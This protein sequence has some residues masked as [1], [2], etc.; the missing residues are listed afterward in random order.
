MA[1]KTRIDR[2]GTIRSITSIART[3]VQARTHWSYTKREAVNR[4]RRIIDD[5]FFAELVNVSDSISKN[6]QTFF[7][8]AVGSSD[9]ANINGEKVVI[10]SQAITDDGGIGKNFESPANADSF[11]VSDVLGFELAS[12]NAVFNVAKIGAFYFNGEGDDFEFFT[13]SVTISD[14]V[15]LN[16]TKVLSETATISDSIGL[17]IQLT[18]SDSVTISDSI[19]QS[20]DPFFVSAATMSDALSLNTQKGLT[21]TATASDS[22]GMSLIIPSVFNA[23]VINLSQFN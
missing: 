6:Q 18:R 14:A 16:N 5:L 1:K 11:S 23:S 10:N 3:R 12:Q 15:G 19:S 13:D 9:T 20:S 2:R 7:T 8:D 22:I 4:R 17:D 21:D